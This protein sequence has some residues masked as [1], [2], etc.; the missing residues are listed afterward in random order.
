VKAH[1][2][3]DKCIEQERTDFSGGICPEQV[4]K[5]K[6]KKGVCNMEPEEHWKHVWGVVFPDYNPDAIPSSACKL[7][8]HRFRPNHQTLTSSDCALSTN[9]DDIVSV[10]DDPDFRR[11]LAPYVRTNHDIQPICDLIRTYTEMRRARNDGDGDRIQG[12]LLPLDTNEGGVLM[13]DLLLHD[14]I[15]DPRP[16]PTTQFLATHFQ[17]SPTGLNP[18]SVVPQLDQ[19]LPRTRAAQPPSDSGVVTHFSTEPTPNSEEYDML[20]SENLRL[21]DSHDATFHDQPMGS[22]FN[23]SMNSSGQWSTLESVS[24]HVEPPHRSWGADD[25][26]NGSDKPEDA[27]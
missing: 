15:I 24:E 21:Y 12:H 1:L 19:S 11:S 14:G 26:I 4:K 9:V 27:Q 5:L 6:S 23:H 3:T 2:R 17:P 22:S 16:D 20:F 8:L 10:L 25:T 18:Y 7:K 13:T